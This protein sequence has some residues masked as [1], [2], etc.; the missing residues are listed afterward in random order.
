MKL[1]A[2]QLKDS[3]QKKLFPIYFISGDEPLQLGEAADAVRLAA[4]KAGYENREVFLVDAKFSWNQLAVA[5]DSLS[6][7]S[8]RQI[9]DLRIPSGKPGKAGAN[10]LTEYC[11]RLPEDTL[12]LI[13]SA[14]IASSS[15]KSRWYQTLDNAGA[16]IQVW[17]LEGRNL[18]LWL[19]NRAQT[20]GLQVEPEG[21]KMLANRVE[22]NL[23][24]AAQEIEK[25]YVLY[26]GGR[27]TSADLLKA[28][29]DNSRF[30]VFK[31]AD[32]VLSGKVDR[33]IRIL[34]G[35]KAEGVAPP[36]VLWSLAREARVLAKIQAMVSRGQNKDNAMANNQ[37]WDKRRS[38]VSAALTRLNDQSLN[39]IL[40]L[41]A[42]A[43]RQ[44]KGEEGGEPWE[45]M[46][47]ICLAFAAVETFKATA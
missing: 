29:A 44:I 28:V 24:A 47:E 31:L 37:V 15:M 33:I 39:R 16:T 4:K 14:K 5:A 7:F 23:L 40:R 34:N 41:S 10:A 8:D 38:L 13:T 2:D 27:L 11:Q 9:I 30:D 25:L 17:P 35:L 3:L 43:D 46:L 45:T 12:L 22:G 26:G 21:L 36:V 18:I 1:K 32:S 6:I 20:R 19:E 42:K